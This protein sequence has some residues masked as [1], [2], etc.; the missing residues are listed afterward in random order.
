MHEIDTSVFDQ[1]D[2]GK[3]PMGKTSLEYMYIEG[4]KEKCTTRKTYTSEPGTIA[5]L[6]RCFGVP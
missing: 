6:L 2:P 1:H 3:T 4:L 5:T